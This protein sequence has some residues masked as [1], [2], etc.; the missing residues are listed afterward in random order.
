MNRRDGR[1]VLWHTVRARAKSLAA[2]GESAYGRR[3]RPEDTIG[4]GFDIGSVNSGAGGCWTR[5]PRLGTTPK[6]FQ[7][8]N[9][10]EVPALI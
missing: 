5:R 4:S 6:V 2:A 10:R 3:S 7:R 1:I 8:K 9:S